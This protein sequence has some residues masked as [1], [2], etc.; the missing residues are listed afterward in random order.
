MG[1]PITLFYKRR[2][3]N[4]LTQLAHSRKAWFILFATALFLELTALFFQHVMK[5]NPCV[6]CVYQ[7]VAVFGLIFAG[8]LGMLQPKIWL[9]RFIAVIGWGISAIW[10]LK[11]AIE[12]YNMQT[13]PSPF[14]TCGFL[15]EFPH[16][17]PL[18]QWFPS[19]FL[20]T[21]LCSEI[22]WSMLGLTMAQWMIFAF[23]LYIVALVIFIWPVLRPNSH[24]NSK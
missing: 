2:N 18:H 4:T 7:R 1:F 24:P 10:G 20:P 16:W 14:E 8:L 19:I 22:P 13:Y 6:M 21:G 23:S 9:V 5:L 3:M 17:L 11:L 12:L 15:P